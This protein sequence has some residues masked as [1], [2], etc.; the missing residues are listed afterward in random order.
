MLIPSIIYLSFE[1]ILHLQFLFLVRKILTC[2]NKK[3]FVYSQI[4]KENTMWISLYIDCNKTKSK[5][6]FILDNKL[7]LR[8][9]Y[10]YRGTELTTMWDG[11]SLYKQSR[12]MFMTLEPFSNLTHG[13]SHIFLFLN[14]IARILILGNQANY[15]RF[16]TVSSRSN[17]R[18]Y[19]RTVPN[20]TRRQCIGILSSRNA[21]IVYRCNLLGSNNLLSHMNY[22]PETEHAVSIRS[23]VS[24]FVLLLHESWKDNQ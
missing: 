17:H 18:R 10:L 7:I 15:T 14:T 5:I 19:L 21:C 2:H 16:V 1:Y 3:Y 24:D 22:N 4:F 6:K 12:I 9:L 11:F 23:W 8:P 13:G 20:C